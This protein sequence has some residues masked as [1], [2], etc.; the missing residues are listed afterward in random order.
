MATK[1]PK[2]V[3]ATLTFDV[4]V[5]V[6]VQAT[7]SKWKSL[8][9]DY[10][11][12]GDSWADQAEHAISEFCEDELALE[13]QEEFFQKPLAAVNTTALRLLDDLKTSHPFIDDIDVEVKL[14][15]VG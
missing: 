3:Q 10:L 14:E 12:E 4:R 15:E 7:K 13:I 2:L 6:N 1:T 11:I 9:K 8:V 5:E